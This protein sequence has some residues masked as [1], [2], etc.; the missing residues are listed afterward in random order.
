M[1][2]NFSFKL[3]EGFSNERPIVGLHRDMVKKQSQPLLGCS[4]SSYNSLS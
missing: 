4:Q 1:E 3:K 2:I